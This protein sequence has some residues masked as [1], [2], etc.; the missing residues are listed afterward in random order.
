MMDLEDGVDAI[1][2]RRRAG[3]LTLAARA[4]AFALLALIV[5]LTIY[6]LM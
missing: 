4:I 3:A 5:V 6:I 2:G 1:S